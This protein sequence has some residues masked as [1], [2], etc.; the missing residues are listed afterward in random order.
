MC[1]KQPSNSE[2]NCKTTNGVGVRVSKPSDGCQRG[3]LTPYKVPVRD[4]ACNFHFKYSI[5][6][7]H[8]WLPSP[9]KMPIDALACFSNLLML[10]RQLTYIKRRGRHMLVL[11][12]KH[13]FMMASVKR[14]ILITGEGGEHVH[15]HKL[16]MFSTLT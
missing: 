8:C 16:Q 1:Y 2:Q 13:T 5:M 7:F 3:L 10:Q 14:K 11:H 12:A 6:G 15:Q 9:H 4:D